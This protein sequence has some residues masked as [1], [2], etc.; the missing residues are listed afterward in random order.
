MA[1]GSV[2]GQSQLVTRGAGPE[3][4]CSNLKGPPKPRNSSPDRQSVAQWSTPPDTRRQLLGSS[5]TNE[6]VTSN[7][8]CTTGV[9]TATLRLQGGCRG[10][11][12]KGCHTG[13]PYT[14][15]S[16]N[17]GRLTATP[18]TTNTRDSLIVY[19]IVRKPEARSPKPEGLKP[20][21]PPSSPPDALAGRFFMTAMKNR[22]FV[23]P[24][25]HCFLAPVI[26]PLPRD[27]FKGGVTPP[28]PPPV[29]Q[30]CDPATLS[31]SPTAPATGTC[32]G[33][34]RAETFANPSDRF[35]N[36]PDNCACPYPL[37]IH[38]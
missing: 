38:T 24:K 32:N 14:A 20:A 35:S 13:V 21:D 15:V 1:I 4:S 29:G 16:A 7:L 23:S 11:K 34:S 36:P 27:A 37:Q 10:G 6:T 33:Q 31:F 8:P 26:R 18:K 30:P 2:S 22:H 12:H 19:F 17:C 3:N 5:P 28:P 9:L 25:V